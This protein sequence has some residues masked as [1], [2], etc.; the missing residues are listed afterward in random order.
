M[1]AFEFS[2]LKLLYNRVMKLFDDRKESCLSGVVVFGTD[3]DKAIYINNKHA[4][5][6]SKLDKNLISQMGFNWLE[7]L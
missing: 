3:F 5:G 6:S 4:K 2:D 7:N 1:F